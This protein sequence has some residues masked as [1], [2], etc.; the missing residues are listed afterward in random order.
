VIASSPPKPSISATRSPSC[1]SHGRSGAVV[2]VV[3]SDQAGELDVEALERMIDRR[4][5]LIVITH[6]PTKW[7]PRRSGGGCRAGLAPGKPI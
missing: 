1:R 7:R 6:V 5:K 4:V 2:G 3:P